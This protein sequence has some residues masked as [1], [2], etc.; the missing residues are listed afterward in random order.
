MTCRTCSASSNPGPDVD[1][2]RPGEVLAF[3]GIGAN[4]GD[5]VAQ[6]E[7]AV[8]RLGATPGVRVLAVSTWRETA[9]VGPV[10]QGPFINGAAALATSLAPRA[11]L[12]VCLDIERAMGRRRTVRWGPR[13]IDLDILLY[14]DRVIDEPGL[15]VPHPEMCARPFV[16]G[17]LAE[18]APDLVHPLTGATMADLAAAGGA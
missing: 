9:P 6:C 14:G 12:D 16:L 4:Q 11:L 13:V 2:A 7:A 18:L 1:A 8:A 15:C 17:P 5:R 3:I 10:A